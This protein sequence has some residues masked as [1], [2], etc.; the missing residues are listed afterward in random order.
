MEIAV[1][2]RSVCFLTV[3]EGSATAGA[4]GSTRTGA[5]G[6]FLREALSP[7]KVSLLDKVVG[8]TLLGEDNW[9]NRAHG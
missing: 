7:L 2:E 9:V 3:A 1:S 5:R 8:Q 4:H 6:S